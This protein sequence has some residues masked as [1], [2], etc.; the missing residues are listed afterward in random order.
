MA[1]RALPLGVQRLFA[2]ARSHYENIDLQQTS[3]GFAPS[4]DDTELD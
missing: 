3:H 2:I 1:K 4:Y